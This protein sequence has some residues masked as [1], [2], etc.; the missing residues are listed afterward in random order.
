MV[1]QKYTL[2]QSGMDNLMEKLSKIAQEDMT[3][4]VQGLLEAQITTNFVKQ[5]TKVKGIEDVIE[6][7]DQLS[8]NFMGFLSMYGFET[9]LDMYL[10]AMSCDLYPLKK[11]AKD[12]SKLVPV[13]RKVMRN[14][15]ETEVTIWEDPNKDQDKGSSSGSTGDKAKGAPKRRHAREFKSDMLKD[16][17]NPKKLAKLKSINLPKGNK[18]FQDSSQFYLTIKDDGGQII[19]IIGYST[20]GEYLVMDFYRSNGEVAGVATRGFFELMKLALEEGYGVKV[21]DQQEARQ[22]FIQVGLQMEKGNWVISA[23][24]LASNFGK[25]GSKSE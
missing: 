19:G 14:G 15:K 8:K 20:E 16:E 2:S 1:R 11:G 18:S 6:R 5:M 17:E 12:Y 3:E 9:M 23:D 4:D 13:K 21:E 7:N 22:V 10:Y 25:S 24:D